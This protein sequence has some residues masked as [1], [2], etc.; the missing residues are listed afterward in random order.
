MNT[1][2]ITGITGQD[3][4]YLA[5]LL[6]NKN[7]EVHGIVRR[8]STVNT[9]RLSHIDSEQRE[10]RLQLHH[11]NLG[12]S[13]N[14][15]SLIESIEPDEIYNLGAQSDVGISFEQPEY[16]TNVNALG[17]LRLL[18]AV[19]Q[20]DVNP[21]FY[22]ASTSEIFGNVSEIPQDE[23]TSFHPR[24]PYACSKLYAHWIT[25]T[26]REAYG[27]FSVNGI[28]FNHESPR[29]GTNF[30]TRKITRGV[31]RITTGQ[32]DCL[33]LGNLDA[34]RDWGYAPEY[35]EA[36][37]KMLQQEEPGDYVIATGETHTVREFASKAFEAA[38][39]DLVWEGEGIDEQGVD[40]ES[41][42]VLVEVN[43]E[44]VRPTE[45]NVLVGDA[46]KAEN[47]F[48]WSPETT[49]QELVNI[50][51]EADLKAQQAK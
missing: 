47:E 24:N 17:A 3:G 38:G 35:V 26:Y 49:F 33:N 13:Q 46:E 21:R 43:P 8:S 20:S 32:K 28:L 9:D 44:F 11:G 30:V 16:T 23:Q 50:M 40:R 29:R 6:L 15:C 10:D 34:R 5:E 25:R 22:Q 1:A 51:V 42:R 4:S 2:L 48:G 36:M 18:E 39:I 41:G 19:R 45:V 14:F 27:F 37:W 31:A 7:Y 12:D